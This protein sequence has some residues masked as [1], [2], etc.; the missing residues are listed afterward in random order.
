MDSINWVC[1]NCHGPTNGAG[2][3]HI[4]YSEIRLAESNRK[5]WLNRGGKGYTGWNVSDAV[6]PP[7][8]GMWKVEC[9][10]CANTCEGSY[11]IGLEQA[12]TAADLDRW[13]EHLSAKSWYMATN[14]AA[15]VCAALE[16]RP[17]RTRV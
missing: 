10:P 11:W 6:A 13:T 5:E 14:W 9:D 16:G 8:L 4:P 7:N 3:I 12:R 15:L 1:D 2:A 17:D